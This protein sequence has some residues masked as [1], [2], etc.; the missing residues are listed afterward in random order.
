VAKARPS[1]E[2]TFATRLVALRRARGLKQTELAGQT[3]SASYVSLL[4][5]GKRPPTADVVTILAARLDTTADYLLHGTDPEAA[6]RLGLTLTYA[7]LA[8]RN[9]EAADALSQLDE[10]LEAAQHAP[11]DLR[12]RA[13]GVRARALEGVNRLDEAIVEMESLR[14]LAAGSRMAEEEL[15]LAVD[16]ARCYQSAGDVNASLDVAHAAMARVNELGLSGSEV[17]A[18]LAST[19]VGAYYVRGDLTKAGI[20]AREALDAVDNQDSSPR[21]RGSVLW[22][23]S[24][25]AE[26][27]GDVDGALVQAERALA[28]FADSDDQRS[29]ARLRVAYG[30][31]LLRSTPPQPAEARTVLSTAHRA[32]QDVGTVADLAGCE[33]ELAVAALMLGDTDEALTLVDEARRRHGDAVTLDAAGTQLI[34]GRVLLA[35][36]RKARAEKQYRAAAATLGQLDVTRQAASAW[37]ELADAYTQLGLFEDAALAYQQALSEVGVRGAPGLSTSAEAPSRP[38]GREQRRR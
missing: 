32:L 33:T 22:N 4:E 31:L 23:A 19:V 29:I 37:R 24:L 5:A 36:R 11:E 26:A 27:R 12:F 7:E 28:L 8:L 17:H 14:T 13:R 20:A 2:E 3:I 6:S 38:A 16:L 1:S 25:V 35:M 15:Q 21:A 9:G 10:A 30:W 18:Q 34:H